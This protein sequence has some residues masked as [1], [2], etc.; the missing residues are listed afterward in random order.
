SDQYIMGAPLFKKITINLE[1][2]KK[3]VINAPE[4]SAEN[5]YIQEAKF[6]GK[7]YTKNW[8]SHSELMK[9][10]TLTLKMGPKPN[11]E[12]GTKEEDFPY[13]F[14]KEKK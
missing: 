1:N 14:S 6:N 8:L 11:M 5:R 7:T 2:G 10:A 4:N 13:S 12:R 3:V 9:G